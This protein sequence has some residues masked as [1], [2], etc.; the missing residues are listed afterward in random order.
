MHICTL[1]YY[2][3]SK[4]APSESLSFNPPFLHLHQRHFTAPLNCGLLKWF[5]MLRKNTLCTV[6]CMALTHYSILILDC[7]GI[8]FT[9]CLSTTWTIH[10]WWCGVFKCWNRPLNSKAPTVTVGLYTERRA[11]TQSRR[12]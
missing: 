6:G 1:Y 5:C 4:P 2:V 8:H 11:H 12:G 3:H 10:V 9:L 7:T